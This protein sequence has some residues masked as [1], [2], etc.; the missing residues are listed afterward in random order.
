MINTSAESLLKVSL[1]GHK[2]KVMA[3][4]YVEIQPY[5][6]DVVTLGVG[7]RTD[8]LIEG[9]NSSTQGAY[10]LRA[11]APHDCAAN[12]GQNVGKAAIYYED[13]DDSQLP[14][15][16]PNDGYDNSDCFNDPLDK[17]VPVMALDPGE[18]GESV[19]VSMEGHSNGTHGKWWMNNVTA[20]VDYSDPILLRAKMGYTDF[21]TQRNVYQYDSS[22]ESVRFIIKNNNGNSHPVSCDRG[23]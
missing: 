17:T 15:S 1:D 4:D 3:N 11:V 10:W 13:A 18:P 19:D 23:L 21:P 16:S 20:T 8:V 9:K 6:T 2:L 14:F 7:Q 22:V 12:D 5:E